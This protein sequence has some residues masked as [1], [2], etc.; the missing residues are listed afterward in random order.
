M[1]VSFKLPFHYYIDISLTHLVT[2]LKHKYATLKKVLPPVLYALHA[3]APT[4]IPHSVL[5]CL[6]REFILLIAIILIILSNVIVNNFI[7]I[8]CSF[9]IFDPLFPFLYVHLLF[10]FAM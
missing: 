8:V 10:L 4:S 2:Q 3:S 1:S 6:Y 9:L 7:Q 5:P